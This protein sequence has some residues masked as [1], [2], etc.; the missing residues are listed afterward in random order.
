MV[1]L[2]EIASHAGVSARPVAP[3]WLEHARRLIADSATARVPMRQIAKQ[4]GVHPVHLSRSFRRQFGITASAYRATLRAQHACVAIV[5]HDRPVSRAA[6]DAGFADQAHLSRT[7]QSAL[8]IRPTTLKR[9][10]HP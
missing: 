2:S 1:R 5:E 8:G 6:H 10:A 9:R 4:V 7:L 3:Q